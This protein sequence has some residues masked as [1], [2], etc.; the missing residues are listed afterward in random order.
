MMI[1]VVL[2]LYFFFVW[3]GFL[4]LFGLVL[5]S[6]YNV[7]IYCLLCM[8]IQIVDDEW[9]IFSI[10]GFFCLQC[11]QLIVWWDNIL[12]FSFF[13]L[14][15]CVCCCQVFIV[16]S[17]LLIELVIGLL[18]IFVGVLLVLGLLL[19]GGLV[20]FLFLLI[21][22]RIDVWIQL[23]FDCLILFLLWVG[24]LFN[25]NEVYIVLL[26]VVVGVMVGYLVLWLV[27]WL[28]CLLIG[29]EVLGYGDFKLLVVLGVW[30]GWQ[31]LLQV[32]LFVLVSG[33]VWILL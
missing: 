2:L 13:W 29:K 26:D 30:C 7:V 28:F 15:C 25:F 32:L 10:L 8:L 11:C 27:Y 24:L 4:L 19:V 17:Y 33:L 21:L 16:W 5:G 14:G 31:V 6:F 23:L 1:L 3:Y 9:I 20:L 22:V 18:F 12:L